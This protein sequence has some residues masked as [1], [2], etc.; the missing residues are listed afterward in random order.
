M[1]TK[2]NRPEFSQ[3]ISAYAP[4]IK[5]QVE[6]IR[7]A[8]ARQAVDLQ[9][10]GQLVNN[11]GA[12]L[13]VVEE[14]AAAEETY[15]RTVGQWIA[16]FNV[17]DMSAAVIA[18]QAQQAAQIEQMVNSALRSAA[19]TQ[20]PIELFGDIDFDSIAKSFVSDDS[21]R[22]WGRKLGLEQEEW[23]KDALL[24]SNQAA[25]AA[26]ALDLSALAV[27]GSLMASLLPGPWLD[28]PIPAPPKER[29]S[30][31][32]TRTGRSATRP[33]TTTAGAHTTS[34]KLLKEILEE[35]KSG[36]RLAAST[37]RAAWLTL[38]LMLL[39]AC[40]ENYQRAN[41]KQ[42]APP[43]N[44]ESRSIIN[45]VTREPVADLRSK[46][47]RQT[48]SRKKVKAAVAEIKPPKRKSAAVKAKKVTP[49]PKNK[50]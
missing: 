45:V 44:Q 49:R 46:A 48:S 12:S 6:G 47:P 38:W 28:I 33:R 35:Q 22:A 10:I 11:Y 32:R 29:R 3:P 25:E 2:N 27:R 19:N 9:A 21:L 4:S 16:K 30:R 24:A 26:Q 20:I 8:Y 14:M 23:V 41:E 34:A 1:P 50:K 37:A 15:R 13:A 5:D 42:P 40:Y 43:A 36:S 39:V 7:E 17:A 31:A 18:S